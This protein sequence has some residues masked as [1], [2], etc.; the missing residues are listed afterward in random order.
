MSTTTVTAHR[1]MDVPTRRKSYDWGQLRTYISAVVILVWCLAPFYWMIVTAFR[2][3]G[4]TFDATPFFTHITWDT[5]A[6]GFDESLGN[7]FGRNLLNSLF[8]SAT[9]TIVALVV[10]VFA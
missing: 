3:V 6:T 1:T 9:T 2:D 7:H 10:G 4:Y 8:V 5:F